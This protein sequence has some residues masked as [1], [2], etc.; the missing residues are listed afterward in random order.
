[1]AINLKSIQRGKKQS[2][3]RMII[4]GCDGVGKST[5]AASAPS[6]IFLDIEDGLANLDVDKWQITTFDELMEAV[7]VLYEDEHKYETVVLDT[8]DWAEKLIHA[9][10]LQ[11]YNNTSDKKAE[12][13]LDIPY[14]KGFSLAVDYWVQLR[15][16]L[17]ALRNDRGMH[18]IL[19][20]HYKIIK[21]SPPDMVD[22]YDRYSLDLHDK[23][24]TLFRE[25]CDICLFLNFKFHTATT[26]K[27][28]F[29]KT[30][31]TKA[32]GSNVIMGYFH[33]R[34][35]AYAKSRYELPEEVEMPKEGALDLIIGAINESFNTTSKK[36]GE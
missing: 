6:P 29:T 25:W 28:D 13:M 10:V 18:V 12:V 32:V 23:A 35:A 20:M 8:A 21:T 3:L 17:D 5:V 27:D 33:D 4:Y 34:P 1:M 16:G 31:I 19:N 24:A 9:K 22:S 7:G 36:E 30:K 2:P 11:E 14:G 26:K 15:D